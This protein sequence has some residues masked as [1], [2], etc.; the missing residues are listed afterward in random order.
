MPHFI[1]DCS[2]NI[3]AMS[4][5]PEVLKMVIYAAR[6]TKL[7]SKNDIKVRVNPYT[8]YDVGGSTKDFIHV[9]GYILQG[10]TED[11]KAMLAKNLVKALTSMFPY[12]E[13]IAASV[14]EFSL[15]GYYNRNL[16]SLN[17]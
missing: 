1:I 3:L 10:R 11:Q 9:F 5:E 2:A 14:E 4:S 13:N 17:F 12:V 15:N 16:L 7:F 6:T 8:R